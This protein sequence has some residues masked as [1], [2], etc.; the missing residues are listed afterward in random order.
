MKLLVALAVMDGVD[1]RGWR[2]DGEVLVRQ[3]DLSLFVQ[4]LAALVPEQGYKTTLGDLVRRAIV[5]SDSAAADILIARLGGPPQVQ[6]FLESSGISG[7][8]LDRDERH[9]QTEILGLTWRPEYVDAA[10]LDRAIAAVPTEDRAAAYRR[11]QADPRDTATPR[12]MAGL[13]QRLATG[14]LLS[15]A[16][17]RYVLHVMEQTVTF[18]DRLKAGVP[19]AWTLGHKTGTS[20]SWQG[21]TA[22]TND[23]G[24]LKA[25]D[26]GSVSVVV[27]IRDSSAPSASRAALIASIAAATTARY[28]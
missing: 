3:Q 22:A 2:L 16:S 25:P 14:G 1:R 19:R 11:Y 15:P 4:P 23:V 7:V 27:F 9:L 28:R 8:R 21:V 26:G 24:V 6:A 18:P 10:A 12:G 5:D 20:S 17:T 13:L